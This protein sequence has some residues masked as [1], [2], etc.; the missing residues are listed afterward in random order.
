MLATIP[1]EQSAGDDLFFARL[2]TTAALLLRFPPNAPVVFR[3]SVAH[4]QGR[5]VGIA[6]A[7]PGSYRHA[8]L[9][10]LDAEKVVWLS[11]ASGGEGLANQYPVLAVPMFEM[12][13]GFILGWNVA[14]M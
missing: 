2:C 9:V 12:S 1:I 6:R 7:D 10:A 11:G 3:S 4:G 5:V 8:V 13:Q 14:T